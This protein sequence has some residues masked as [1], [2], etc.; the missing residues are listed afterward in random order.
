MST[1][2]I[3]MSEQVEC[4]TTPE[5]A[6][7]GAEAAAGRDELSLSRSSGS[8]SSDSSEP[9]LKPPT[10][11]GVSDP[12]N[13]FA[14]VSAPD[15]RFQVDWRN[16][17]FTVDKKISRKETRR[18][19]ILKGVSGVAKPG[20]FTAI[21][22]AS[23]A[24][25]SSTLNILA[26]RLRSHGDATVTGEIL[27]NGEP[28]DQRHFEQNSAY[29]MQHDALMETLT[30]REAFMFA[31]KLR[32]PKSLPLEVK[33]ERV[34]QM[35]VAL[36]LIK[37]ADS[38]I[39]GEQIQGISGGERKRVSIG[40]ELITNPSIIFTD[41]PTSGLDSF[42]A[43]TTVELLVNLAHAGDRT[44]MA[45]IHQPNSDM[46]ELFDDLIVMAEGQVMYIGPADE[47][48]DYFKGL[49][50]PCRQYSNPADFF[51]NLVHGRGD[52]NLQKRIDLAQNAHNI[53]IEPILKAKLDHLKEQNDKQGV[54][55]SQNNDEENRKVRQLKAAGKHDKAS[56]LEQL[57]LLCWRT[58]ANFRRQPITGRVRL[59]QNVFFALLMGILFFD[60][61]Q[62]TRAVQG[63]V[64]AIFATLMNQAMG[65]L[66]S[67]ILTFPVE[68]IMFHRERANG[69]YSTFSYFFAK[70]VVELPYNVMY[71][72][73]F[74]AIAYPM[75]GFGSN[76]E[77]GLRYWLM[78]LTIAQVA[79]SLGILLGAF[80][81]NAQAAMSASSAFV[82]PFIF[83]SGFFVN[84][85]D[86]PV[87]ISWLSWL[88][89]A[90]YGIEALIVNEFSDDFIV[91]DCDPNQGCTNFSNGAEIRAFYGY[92]DV[93]F[94]QWWAVMAGMFIFFLALGLY[95][96]RSKAKSQS[97]EPLR[98]EA[99]EDV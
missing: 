17:K 18:L 51:I 95:F 23:G 78:L 81:P 40:I 77:Q 14:A 64:G 5:A 29:V 49:G 92:E 30:P 88:S 80:M 70:V 38:Y 12:N 54:E 79:Y 82:L 48:V 25:K 19:E 42:T 2:A 86:M 21:L 43:L 10:V 9:A 15:V 67:V 68:K 47:A 66:M 97:R 63:R 39:G 90:K 59:G 33:Q 41:E 52:K 6:N 62:S 3:P 83:F 91:S 35:L 93:N 55:S 87:W 65:T 98:K 28:L 11:N 34:E 69:M 53:L 50:Y 85:D 96:L 94:W 56:T 71:T 22:G 76:F 7:N 58:S 4:E 31:A 89:W 20:R 27:I 75:I 13:S 45:T 24:G 60:L 74:V 26:G 46:F 61:G 73:I 8:L 72:T 44:V 84:I 32:L 1:S 99:P 16:L 37:C 36:D 57:K